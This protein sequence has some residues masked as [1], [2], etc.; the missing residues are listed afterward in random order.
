MEEVF[1]LTY[2]TSM[3]F[4][5]IY[6]LPI[7]YRKWFITRLIKQKDDELPKK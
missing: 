6:N 1:L 2:Y 3:T 4:Q 5:D 7:S